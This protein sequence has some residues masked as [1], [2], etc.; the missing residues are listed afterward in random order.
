MWYDLVVLAILLFATIRGA[1]KGIVWQLAVIAAVVLCFVFSGSLSLAIAP[2]L[3]IDPPLNRW[4]AM[5]ALY[6]V[7]AFVSFGVARWLKAWIEKLKF[8][9]LDR[10]LG[11][12]FG[13][14][15]GATIALVMTFFVVTLGDRAPTVRDTV[16]NSWSGRAAAIIM[17]RLHP[18]MPRELHDTLEPYIHQLDRPGLDLRHS[19]DPRLGQHED[20]DSPGSDDHPHGQGNPAADRTVAGDARPG[21]SPIDRADA[22]FFADDP[23]FG[24]WFAPRPVPAGTMRR[25]TDAP[26]PSSLEER[27]RLLRSIGEISSDIPET[28]QAI[29]ADIEAQLSSVSDTVALAVLRDWHADLTS[30]DHGA[31]PD[32]GTDLHTTLDVRITRQLAQAAATRP[33]LSSAPRSADRR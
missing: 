8:V 27:R 6:V 20:H 12:V 10:H 21:S 9:E 29:L 7:F 15:K 24:N 31:D 16:F 26:S 4:V 17:D 1:I 3:G 2:H 23:L 19:H 30:F 33:P 14:I 5:F 25:P 22:G 18:V 13:L 32:P 28:Q 11:A